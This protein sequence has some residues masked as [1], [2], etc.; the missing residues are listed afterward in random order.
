MPGQTVE[1]VVERVVDG[2]TVRVLFG[3]RS[4]SLRLQC[5]DTEESQAGGEKPVTPWGKKTSEYAKTLLP[6]GTPVRI[7]LESD[8]PLFDPDGGVAVDHLDNFKRLLGFLMLSMPV[9]EGGAPTDDYQELM[10][11]Q[12]HSPYFVKYG[13]VPFAELD[14]R[15]GAAE[16]AAQS[17]DL[18]LWDQLAVNGAVA[19][20]Y[21]ALGVWWELRSQLVDG[22]RRAREADASGSL[23]NSR[24]DYARLVELAGAGGTTTVFL[25]LREMQPIGRHALIDTG[26]LAQPFKLFIPDADAPERGPLRRLLANR[27][28][29]AD[30]TH[31]GRNYA[32]VTGPLQLWRDLPEMVVTGIEQLSDVPPRPPEA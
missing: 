1:A 32:Y 31:P 23:L 2:D 21:A 9:G 17:G 12:G 16:R 14:A 24:R 8:A 27:Y 28:L 29:G 19:R 30:E 26:S 25:E 5:L 11:R 4:V 10:I 15:Y 22:F 3:A 18:G 20:D 7:L 13:R 6:P